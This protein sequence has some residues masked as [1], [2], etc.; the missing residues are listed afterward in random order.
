[1]RFAVNQGQD[2]RL[3]DGRV[4]LGRAV[5][6][7]CALGFPVL[8]EEEAGWVIA[9]L[10]DFEATAAW[11]LSRKPALLGQEVADFFH[12]GWVFYRKPDIE[13]KHGPPAKKGEVSGLLAK[14]V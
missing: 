13:I 6:V 9:R 10:I 11:L 5:D 8:G 1:M 14:P 7:E 2:F 3:V 4:S 12:I